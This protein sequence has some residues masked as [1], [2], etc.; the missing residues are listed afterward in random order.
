MTLPD[1]LTTLEGRGLVLLSAQFLPDGATV[2]GFSCGPGESRAPQPN[3]PVREPDPQPDALGDFLR[4]KV[5]GSEVQ[6]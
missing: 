5:L 1:L 6:S 2:A 4:G 3:A